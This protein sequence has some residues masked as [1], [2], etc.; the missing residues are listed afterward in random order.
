MTRSI[1]DRI[2]LNNGTEMPWL[3]LGVWKV[4][5][6]EKLIRSV[7]T[8]LDYGYRSIDTATIYGNEA[9]VGK[10]IRQSGVPREELFVTTKLWNTEHGYER[11]ISA[12]EESLKQLKLD[13]IDL[14][15]IHW[16][17]RDAF[18]ETW[19]A[20]IKLYE[21]GKI[22]AIGVSNF[23]TH[24]LEEIIATS[25]I[26][27]AVNQIEL[28]PRLT[29]KPLL[30]FCRNRG[31]QVEAWSPLMRG[32]LMDEPVLTELASRLNKS[33]AQIILRWNLQ[34]GIA[35]IPKSVTTTRIIENAGI[36]DFELSDEAMLAI[37]GLNQDIR[38]GA[39]PDFF[40]T[41]K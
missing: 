21:E 40:D 26:L 8:A 38:T 12:F 9:E 16:P 39:H 20:F 37:D 1:T 30:N 28:H 25:D 6:E 11:T 18:T 24:H 4:R 17:V 29:Q 23:Q 2:R 19:R 32:R 34:L 41:P 36:F 3:G 7:R 22:K 31:I 35:T 27:P 33:V 10:A 13:Y 5:E 15:L 14:Y